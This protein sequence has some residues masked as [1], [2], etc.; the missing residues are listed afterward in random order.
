VVYAPAWP[1]PPTVPGNSLQRLSGPEYGNDPVN[2]I[3]TAASAGLFS[4]AADAPRLTF[5]GFTDTGV[6]LSWTSE[7]GKTY[8]ILYTDELGRMDWQELPETVVATEK[9]TES[10][11]SAGPLMAGRYYRIVLDN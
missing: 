11:V 8:R 7:P 4:S 6:R 2:W 1:W 10:T 9:K 3:M 5:E